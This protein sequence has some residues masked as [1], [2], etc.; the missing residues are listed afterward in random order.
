MGKE[1]QAKLIELT[2]KGWTLASIARAL[3]LSHRT[4]ESWNQGIR[5][6]ANL[7]SVLISLDALSKR[8]PPKMKIYSNK[9]VKKGGQK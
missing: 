6:P 7:H 9:T 1:I 3:H 8:K 2:Q 5:S 4:V